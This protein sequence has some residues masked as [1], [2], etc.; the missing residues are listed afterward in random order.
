MSTFSFPLWSQV[1]RTNFHT[2]HLLNSL[3]FACSTVVGRS[4]STHGEHPALQITV[5]MQLHYAYRPLNRLQI[6]VHSFL[7]T[8][9][10]Y[11]RNKRGLRKG[12]GLNSNIMATFTYLHFC[13]REHTHWMCHK[14]HSERG[15]WAGGVKTGRVK[16]LKT[17][18][19]VAG[20]TQQGA[21]TLLL[22]HSLPFHSQCPVLCSISSLS[23]VNNPLT[24]AQNHSRNISEANQKEAHC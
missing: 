23:Q 21:R 22:P 14:K 5:P 9:P 1:W 2:W 18:T 15:R 6:S 12:T 17:G 16:A 3:P 24:K 8:T 11:H 7:H 13:L 10:Q 4:P 20:N 19:E